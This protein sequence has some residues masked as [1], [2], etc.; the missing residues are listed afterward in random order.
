MVSQ[1]GFIGLGVM[2]EP[3][4]SNL[5]KAGHKLTILNR[6]TEAARKLSKAGA[7]VANSIEELVSAV[8]VVFT[9]LPADVEVRDVYF[10]SKGVLEAA[11]KGQLLI[12]ASSVSPSTATEISSR[13]EVNGIDFVDAPVS[14]GDKGAREATLSIMV[15]GTSDGF[16]RAKPLLSSLGQKVIHVGDSGA[17]QVVKACNQVVVAGVISALSEGLM[18]AESHGVPAEILL[19]VLGAGLAGTK[20]GEVRRSN[21]ITQNFTPGFRVRLHKKDLDIALSAAARNNIHLPIANVVHGQ[22]EKLIE[23]GSGDL[24]HTAISSLLRGE[25]GLL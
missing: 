10:G 17:G 12:D 13:C 9:M 19:D 23:L 21:F 14:G 18:L 3:M 4:A 20:V 8:D 22:F 25:S 7:I 16:E 5:L 11:R 2:G 15:G 6:G 1:I 24:D